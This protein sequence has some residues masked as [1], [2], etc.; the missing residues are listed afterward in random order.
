MTEREI[1]EWK[2]NLKDFKLT[3]EQQVSVYALIEEDPDDFS[4]RSVHRQR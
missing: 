1:N 3:K 2:V 4:L